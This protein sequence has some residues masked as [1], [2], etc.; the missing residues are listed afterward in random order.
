M[1]VYSIGRDVGCDI[2]I[3]DSTDVVSRRHAT[4]NVTSTGKMTIVD[5]SYNGTYVN[6]IRIS[7]NVP[8]PVT[9]KDNI[10]FAHVAR[11]DWNLIPKSRMPLYFAA[12]A[13]AVIIIVA[14]LII[15]YNATSGGDKAD[16]P[17][18]VQ[19]D[20]LNKDS[21]K[22]DTVNKDSVKK[23]TDKKDSVKRS[24]PKAKAEAQKKDKAKQK[25]KVGKTDNGQNK[26]KKDNKK[27]GNN[28]Q[29][30]KKSGEKNADEGANWRH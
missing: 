29:G 26:N 12:A 21:V 6:G 1:K 8:V 16:Q 28:K 15:G 13:I 3:N 23:E 24:K 19:T 9:R 25:D 5:S 10:S 20:T 30:N 18:I 4:L 11:L 17:S 7:Q 2:V 27:E 14:G 22:K